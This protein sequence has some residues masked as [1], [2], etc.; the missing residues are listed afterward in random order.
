MKKTII[1]RLGIGVMLFLIF[2]CTPLAKALE[3]Q[4]DKNAAFNFTAPIVN[5]TNTTLFDA[6]LNNTAFYIHSNDNTTF[7]AAKTNKTIIGTSGVYLF[8]LNATEMNHDRVGILI[9]DS[10]ALNDYFI[11]NTVPKEAIDTASGYAS[12]ANT[13]AFS[14]NASA[15]AANATA[16]A[17]NA[18]VNHAT[19]GNSIIQGLA[20]ATNATVNHVTYG[21]SPIKTNLGGLTNVTLAA[22]QTGVTI[23]TVTTLTNGVTVTTNNDKTGYSLATAPP[24]KAE[25]RAEMDANSTQLSA[26]VEDTGTTIPASLGGLTN[27]TLTSDYDA[28]KTASQFNASS[29]YVKLNQ[30]TIE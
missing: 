28:A 10:G 27:V 8:Q 25:I 21:L 23:P 18:T 7:A 29:D 13:S 9:N 19:Y 12:G 16:S 2:L 24:T 5:A 30:T 6:A 4:V 1:E 26:I 3:F 15:F 20:S 17:A 11:I 22:T 14:A